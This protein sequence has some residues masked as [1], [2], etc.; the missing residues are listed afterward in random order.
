MKG[1]FDPS[2]RPSNKRYV[3]FTINDLRPTCQGYERSLK[4]YVD[5]SPHDSLKDQ[6][7][8]LPHGSFHLVIMDP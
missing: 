8:P 3:S 1:R 6:I 4:G 2:K 5:P 7:E